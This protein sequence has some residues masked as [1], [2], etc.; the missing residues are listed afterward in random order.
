MAGGNGTRH[1]IGK[2]NGGVQALALP[3]QGADGFYTV[4]GNTH[5][6]H[7]L[8]SRQVNV[9]HHLRTGVL[10]LGRDFILY[11]A[12]HSSRQDSFN[13]NLEIGH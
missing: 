7:Q 3:I 2:V 10:N 6:D 5:G 4:Q 8:G 9:G 11:F 1:H 13:I 12:G